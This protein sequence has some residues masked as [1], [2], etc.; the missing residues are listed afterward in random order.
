MSRSRLYDSDSLDKNTVD[1][2]DTV[3]L[4][5]FLNKFSLKKEKE[6]EIVL[7]VVLEGEEEAVPDEIPSSTIELV[8]RSGTLYDD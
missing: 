2:E 1:S 5:K 8:I 4:G 6:G 7:S 3:E